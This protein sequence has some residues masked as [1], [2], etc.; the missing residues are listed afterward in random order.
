MK[1]FLIN[2]KNK[3]SN[4]SI[5]L[6]ITSLLDV[7]SIILVFLLFSYNPSDLKLDLVTNLKLAESLS[8]KH[9]TFAPVIQINKEL[10]I[11]YESKL[12]GNINDEKTLKKIQK[13]L[14][15]DFEK[16]KIEE[17]LKGPK[18]NNIVLN[19]VID[20]SVASKHVNQIMTTTALC[21][22]EK[23]KFIVGPK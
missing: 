1:K 10:D 9:T 13:D 15:K 2:K 17:A 21:G 8:K 19:L 6:D 20:Q 7:L 22:F 11:F 16:I 14:E 18:K 4:T 12:I 3:R 5:D 23:F